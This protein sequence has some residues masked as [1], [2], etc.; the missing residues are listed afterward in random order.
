MTVIANYCISYVWLYSVKHKVYLKLLEMRWKT[1]PRMNT[2][3]SGVSCVFLLN[4]FSGWLI[5]K[6][7]KKKV[8][9]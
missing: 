5:G 8:T 7:E 9:H 2:H 6:K 3:K 1:N 4:I